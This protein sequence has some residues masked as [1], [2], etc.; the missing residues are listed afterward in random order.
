M[1]NQFVPQTI[2]SIDT[3]AS[4]QYID[5]EITNGDYECLQ[6][7]KE[8]SFN[9]I[10][11]TPYILNPSKY[12]FSVA[13]FELQT[14]T[15]PV[16]IPKIDVNQV[17]LPP[18][19]TGNINQ[20]IYYMSFVYASVET[21][22]PVF[23]ERVEF[24]TVNPVYADF[25]GRQPQSSYYYSYTYQH[26]L[27]C[28]NTCMS[29]IVA[30]MP[31]KP[32]SNLLPPE[33]IYDP[34]TGKISLMADIAYYNVGP[35][36]NPVSTPQ[37]KIYMNAPL[38]RLL[39]SFEYI[40]YGNPINNPTSNPLQYRL[41]VYQTFNNVVQPYGS[42]RPHLIMTGEQLDVALWNPIKMISFNTSLIPIRPTLNA[43]PNDL[44][45]D[46]FSSFG[47]NSNLTTTITDFEIAFSPNNTYKQT[48]L[49]VPSGE[50][51]LI[52]L[53]SDL[54]FYQLNVS[55]FWKDDAGN[56]I[57]LYLTGG[58]TANLKLLFRRKDFNNTA[59]LN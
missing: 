49:Y 11:N 44:G 51:R 45:N 30:D 40:D 41:K 5:L 46:S 12:F 18:A 47:N 56:L 7:P 33:F 52:D 21:T 6:N 25:N 34:E 3:D 16:F 54:P 53:V 35:G 8:L 10:R 38:Q 15:L 58:S 42:T 31:N 24:A 32:T 37:V 4:H 17:I 36:F 2:K 20:T 9:Q 59:Y 28:I 14:S 26:F 39:S 27:N 1:F 23:W 55:V 19:T 57:P 50:Y 48:I 13:R 29:N 22:L 43:P